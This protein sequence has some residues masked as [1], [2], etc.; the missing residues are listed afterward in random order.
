M[1]VV[2]IPRRKVKLVSVIFFYHFRHLNW[3]W[4]ILIS[5]NEHGGWKF[6]PQSIFL[7]REWGSRQQS[8][9]QVMNVKALLH[10]RIFLSFVLIWT[11]MNRWYM[12]E[13]ASFSGR[14]DGL[15][16]IWLVPLK[17]NIH[18]FSFM[19]I[20]CLHRWVCRWGNLGNFGYSSFN[21]PFIGLMS[22]YLLDVSLSSFSFIS[23]RGSLVIVRCTA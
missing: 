12:H 21:F 17:Q 18:R 16:P 8:C 9:E 19:F 23:F 14:R 10:K 15:V 13:E 20:G 5:G 6:H 11:M 4:F 1:P 2:L 22:R 7:P 3:H